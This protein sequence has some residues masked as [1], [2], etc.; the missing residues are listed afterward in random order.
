MPDR[1][2]NIDYRERFEAITDI[3]E[4]EHVVLIG[5]HGPPGAIPWQRLA[6]STPPDHLPTTHPDDRCLLIYTS[7]TTADPKGVQHTTNTLIAEIRTS[8]TATA[9]GRTT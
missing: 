6:E 9:A 5:E 1:W 2:R 3:P 4:L 7:G 8:A